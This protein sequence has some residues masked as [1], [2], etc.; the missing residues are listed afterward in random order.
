MNLLKYFD[1]NRRAARRV[2]R[3]KPRDTKVAFVQQWTLNASE[4]D[5]HRKSI[6]VTLS[7]FLTQH[8]EGHL[9]I[10]DQL[11]MYFGVLLGVYFSGLIRGQDFKPTL[12]LASLL[13]LVIIPVV[14]EK[15]NVNPTAPL[16]VR[17][18]LFVQNGVFWDVLLQAIGSG[19][20]SH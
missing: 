17:F 12:L 14:F 11:V 7:S 6:I 9:S 16:L 18:G 10:A 1:L 2:N 13:A 3:L 4:T 20:R 8:E 15:L 5:K 19:L